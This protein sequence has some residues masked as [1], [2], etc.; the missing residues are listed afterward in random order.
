MF[1]ELF[2]FLLPVA[3]AT[4]WYAGSRSDRR[5]SHQRRQ[6]QRASDYYKGLNYLLN[7]QPDKAI[8]V[9][10]NMPDVDSETVETHTA[11]GNLFRRR[12]EVDR[13]IRIHQNLIARPTLTRQQRAMALL[14]LGQDYMR[15]GL[16]DRAEGLFQELVEMDLHAETALEQL[17]TIYQMEKEWDGA[18]AAAKK[19]ETVSGRPMGSL[20]AQFVCELAEL[21]RSRAHRAQVL[22]LLSD[23]HG[24]DRYCVRATLLQGRMQAQAGDYEAAIQTYQRVEYQDVGLISEVIDPLSECYRSLG[25]TTEMRAYFQG[26]LE[27]HPGIAPVLRLTDLIVEQDGMHEAREFISEQLRLRPSIRGIERL[28]C[29]SSTAVSEEGITTLRTVRELVGRLLKDRPAYRCKQ[30]GFMCNLLHWQCPGC[31]QW[32]SIKPI[33]DPIYE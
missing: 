22:S 23:A 13:A 27:R 30:C 33:E 6:P 17:L 9:F 21:A 14:E 2:W 31:K 5:A 11:L 10:L 20:I 25:R 29:L 12:G 24:S 1:W 28:L 19:L 18:I 32:S 26:L 15:A 7:E 16:F 3:A 8:E 4:G